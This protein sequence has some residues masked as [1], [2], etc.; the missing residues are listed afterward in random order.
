[1]KLIHSAIAR[2]L[3]CILTRRTNSTLKSLPLS[4]G[5]GQGQCESSYRAKAWPVQSA[6]LPPHRVSGV[7]VP[8]GQQWS[9]SG[10]LFQPV[11]SARFKPPPHG[12]CSLKF[13]KS[14]GIMDSWGLGS[15]IFL[16]LP[17]YCVTP[18]QIL[19][20]VPPIFP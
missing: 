19:R 10:L 20:V 16:L 8:V 14:W 2:V 18:A 13:L 6:E 3:C 9:E 17:G 12:R 7:I 4:F 15:P 5:E 11:W 1:M